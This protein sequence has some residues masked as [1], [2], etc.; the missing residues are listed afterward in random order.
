MGLSA[1]AAEA[2]TK[3]HQVSAPTPAIL[4]TPTDVNIPPRLYEKVPNLDLYKKL[5]AAEHRLDLFI[6]QKSLDFQAVQAASLNPHTNKPETGTLRVFV[7]NTCENMPWQKTGFEERPQDASWTLHVEGRFI[8]DNKRAADAPQVKL[9]SLLQGISIEIVPNSDYPALQGNPTNIIEWRDKGDMPSKLP[10][11]PN[12]SSLRVFDGIQVKRQGTFNIKTKI[13]I[14]AKDFSARLQLTP[15]MAQFCGRR[16]ASQQELIYQIWQY[17][18]YK[19]L[20][21]QSDNATKV[22]AVSLSMGGLNAEEDENDISLVVCDDTLKSLLK[23]DVFKFRDLYKLI[24]PLLAP[25]QPI[26]I[27]YE[28]LTTQLT[29]LGNVVIDIPM[30]L[31]LSLSSIQKEL[32]EENKQ[33]FEKMTKL[34]EHIQLLN[35]RILLGIAALQNVNAREV[36]YRELSEDPVGF[37]K[38]WLQSQAETLK[39]LKSEEGYNEETVRRAKFF[40]ENEDLLKQKIDLMLGAQKL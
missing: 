6:A 17:V 20:F 19:G 24:Q 31:Q 35:Q 27:D 15:E 10:G 13:A 34:D 9:S 16:E 33:A 36:F 29:T 21:K 40:E 28:V 5:Q 22:P 2:P 25:R 4:Y 18:L 14:L 7:Y 11:N 26:V 37:L 1:V 32:V 12:E 30:E 23:V 3:V 38:Q 39:A 8:P